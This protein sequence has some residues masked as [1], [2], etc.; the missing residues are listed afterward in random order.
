MTYWF[1]R[2]STQGAI[3][4]KPRVE[5]SDGPAAAAVKGARAG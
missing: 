4:E 3:V 5:F 1:F 2:K